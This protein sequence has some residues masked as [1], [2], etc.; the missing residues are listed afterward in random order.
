MVVVMRIEVVMMMMLVGGDSCVV[1]RGNGDGVDRSI[2]GK[3]LGSV[4]ISPSLVLSALA[5]RLGMRC[6]LDT[7]L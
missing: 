7:T 2:G 3:E 6:D 5:V 1:E 4:D